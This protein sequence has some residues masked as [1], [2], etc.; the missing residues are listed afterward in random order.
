VSS[1]CLPRRAVEFRWFW[2]VFSAN[3][4]TGAKHAAFSTNHLTDTN[5]TECNHD[6]KQCKKTQAHNFQEVL[7]LIVNSHLR[8]T[9]WLCGNV[10][11]QDSCM[12]KVESTYCKK[13]QCRQCE[14]ESQTKQCLDLRVFELHLS[15]SLLIDVNWQLLAQSDHS[16][17]TF[18]KHGTK[19]WR[20]DWRRRR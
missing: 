10:S 18:N 8:E 14:L 20:D 9:S 4:L 3:C 11:A 15:K 17:W 6:R 13:K 1:A 5:K 7:Y 12:M 19:D 2:R 16:H